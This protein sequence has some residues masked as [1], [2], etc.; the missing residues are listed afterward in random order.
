MLLAQDASKTQTASPTAKVSPPSCRHCP[1]PEFPAEARKAQ[2]SAALVLLDVMILENGQ[3]D[4]IRVVS[5]PGYGFGDSA[6]KTVKAWKFKP[7]A[8][9]DSTKVALRVKIEIKFR[10]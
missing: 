7:A 2:I 10:E 6:V 9:K 5:D 4:D 8:K 1:D 3:T